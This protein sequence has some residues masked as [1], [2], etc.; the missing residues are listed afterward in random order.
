MAVYVPVCGAV[1]SAA[2]VQLKEEIATTKTAILN[3]DRQL[4][5]ADQRIGRI[6][7]TIKTGNKAGEVC[8]SGPPHQPLS[9]SLFARVCVRACVVCVLEGFGNCEVV[10]SGGTAG[11]TSFQQ[12][13]R[14]SKAIFGE[15]KNQSMNHAITQSC[16]HL[17]C[18][19]PGCAQTTYVW[20]RKS[21]ERTSRF[22]GVLMT[23]LSAKANVREPSSDPSALHR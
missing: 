19:H 5:W 15:C 10:F 21:S 3:L 22:P 7:K 1:A 12:G 4:E 23:S 16:A 13:A 20:S 17:L 9:L 2:L 14:Y 18:V 11:G 8:L 6:A